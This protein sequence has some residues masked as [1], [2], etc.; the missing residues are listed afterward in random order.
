MTVAPGAESAEIRIY[1]ACLAA[2]NGGRLHGAWVSAEQDADGIQADVD[3]M[4]A[5]SPEPSAEEWAIHDSE[6]FH[7]MT[8]DE[9]ESFEHVAELAEV[10]SEHGAAY[11]AYADVVGEH[12]ANVGGFEDA[13]RGEWD[14]EEAYAIDYIESTGVLDSMPDNLRHY[15][16]WAAWTRDLFMDYVSADSPSGRRGYSGVYVFECN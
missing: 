14:S 12:Y 4:L 15:F 16:D 7:G 9:S 3:A 11:A 10:L 6:G 5:A 1:V 8:I 13:Y 2:Y